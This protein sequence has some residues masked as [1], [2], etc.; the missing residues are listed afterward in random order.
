VVKSALWIKVPSEYNYKTL[1]N[2]AAISA[3][4]MVDFVPF[5]GWLG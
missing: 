3:M 4:A 5:G 1:A 2:L